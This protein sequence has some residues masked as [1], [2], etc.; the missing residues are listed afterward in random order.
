[1]RWHISRYLIHS[2]SNRVK[3]K[4]KKSLDSFDLTALS[5]NDKHPNNLFHAAA[6]RKAALQRLPPPAAETQ[7]VIRHLALASYLTDTHQSTI[8]FPFW[9]LTTKWNRCFFFP[10]KMSGVSTQGCLPALLLVAFGQSLAEA[11]VGTQ[12]QGGLALL[13]TNGQVG[14]VRC[15]KACNGCG[16][17]LLCPLGAQAHD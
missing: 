11:G 12:V 3:K 17:L 1:M 5:A 14:S 9:R 7:P 16:A 8:D 13:V 2:N 4:K 6:G 15:Q 10:P